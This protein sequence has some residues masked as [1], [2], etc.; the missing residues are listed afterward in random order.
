MVTPRAPAPLDPAVL[1]DVLTSP[2]PVRVLPPNPPYSMVIIAGSRSPLMGQVE[3]FD[4]A[5]RPR[6]T[7][8]GTVQV[9]ARAKRGTNMDSP[10]TYLQDFPL[11]NKHCCHN[12]KLQYT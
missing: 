7:G 5:W 1:S 10:F 12:Q 11:T 3:V 6:A 4:G 2:V 8:A 9:T